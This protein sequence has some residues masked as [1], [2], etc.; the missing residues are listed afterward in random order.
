MTNEQWRRVKDEFEQTRDVPA[1]MRGRV[2][3][4][5]DD[6]EIR[7]E[8]EELLRAYDGSPQFLE[9]PA[10]LHDSVFAN[11]VAPGQRLGSYSLVRQVGEGGM[12][13]VYEAVRA[14][15]EFEQRA[16]IKV[17][18]LWLTSEE[19]M[20]RFRGERQ[21]LARLDHPNIAR[22]IDGGTTPGGLP[23]LVMEF[24][25]GI[26]IDNYCRENTL[27][28]CE[29]LRLF[30]LVC[31]TVEYAHTQGI[32]H[33]DLKPANILVMQGGKPKLLD[34]GIAKVIDPSASEAVTLTMSRPAT[35]QYASPEQLRGEP[36][37]P[38]SDIYSLGVLLYELLTGQSPYA[39]KAANLQAISRAVYEEEPPPPSE[40][41]GNAVWR[42]SLDRIVAGAMRKDPAARY[43][44]VQDLIADVDRYLNGVAVQARSYFAGSWYRR[45]SVW[46]LALLVVLAAGFLLLKNGPNVFKR[47]SAF[48]QV[49]SEGMDRER[50]S[51]WSAARSLFR[52]ATDAEPNNPLGHYAYS[53]ALH[54]LG[55]ESLAQR[56]AKLANDLAA[57]LSQENQLLIR[58]R[59]QEYTQDK[60]G[61]VETYR[62]LVQLNRKNTDYGLRL[63]VAQAKAGAPTDAL[64]TLD[65]VR[66]I[67]AGSADDARI[68][69][70]RARAFE[71]LSRYQQELSEARA[72]AETAERVG[73]RP[74]K[75]E[76][77]QVEGDALRGMNRFDEAVRVYADSE[78]LSREDGDL[79]EVASIENRLGGMSFNQGDYA[80]LEA[81]SNTALALFRQIDNKSAQ[82]SILNNLSLAKK[83]RGDLAGALALI[84]QAFAI[85][86]EGEDLHGQTGELTN[87]GLILRRLGR[88][89]DAKKAFE[90]SLV[91][92]QRLGDRDQMAR[93]HLTLE[94]LNR[95]NGDLSAA[96]DHVRTAQ[97]L[98]VESKSLSLKA[99]TLQHLGDDI[100]ASGDTEQ[101][102]SVLEQSSVLA[103]QANSKQLMAD[104]A[105]MLA[106]IAREQRD[107]HRG[108]ELLKE[109]ETYYAA[110][111]QK[112]NLWDA[113]VTE[114]RLRIAE[115]HAARTEETI[116]QAANGFHDVKDEARE[117]SAESAL[118]E[119]YLAQEKPVQAARVFASSRAICSAT[120]EYEWRMLYLIRSIQVKA[121]GDALGSREQMRSLLREL[122]TKG[123]GQLV[124][125]A[126]VAL[127]R[128]LLARNR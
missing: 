99:L 121:V 55:Y 20:N 69:L 23:F 114:A 119:S 18:K 50:H 108:E 10:M 47:K 11:H 106:D 25:E 107:F 6:A 33:R 102:K 4:A 54:T 34:F 81:H 79:F 109:A 43:S 115:G 71:L 91:C 87:M 17:V 67:S 78:A 65:S 28:T 89:G 97:S 110:Q 84:Q 51:D 14:D 96:L 48:E 125:E 9:L 105:Y 22:L 26:R 128:P 88:E 61:A 37:T 58:G 57:S 113:G 53:A 117:C 116:Q 120:H 70:Q 39:G 3:A 123:W 32:V 19:E 27:D 41:T 38:S 92:A 59:Y 7:R 75:A 104:N 2:L 21:I 40:I 86:S 118:I 42:Q 111:R 44:S 66:G 35:P 12:G 60:V 124:R 13:V 1:E 31:E 62:K 77:L 5:V 112:V 122:Q 68:R 95:D 74:L 90:E 76:A 72:A 103:R 52:R 46:A 8:L 45:K 83:F 101:G 93:S 15:G 29:R 73:E 63:A 126:R 36:T 85:S 94:G 82:S 100:H 24:V 16:A 127:N 64:Q 49:Y 56:E 30:R 98:L 80:A